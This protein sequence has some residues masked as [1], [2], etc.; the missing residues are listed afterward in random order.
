MGAAVIALM[1]FGVKTNDSEDDVMGGFR[2]QRGPNTVSGLSDVVD[3]TSPT[4]GGNL[5]ANSN[6]ITDAGTVSS[7]NM[8]SLGSLGI[9]ANTA[10]TVN[11]KGEIALDT[12]DEQFLVGASDDSARVMPTKFKIW[13][14][15]IASTTPELISGGLLPIPV[16]LDGYTMTEIRCKTVGGTSQV[17]AVEDESTNSTED[18]TCLNTVTSDDGSITNAAVTAAEEMYIDFGATTGA[19]DYVSISVFGTW[20][21]E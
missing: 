10:P 1:A 18:I 21:R 8:M 11:L 12:T 9:P 14:A 4:L 13:S 20:T 2:R 17:V 19:I 16:D 3:D 6:N 7:T 5:D 15:T